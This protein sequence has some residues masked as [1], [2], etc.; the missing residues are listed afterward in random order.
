MKKRFS[1]SLKKAIIIVAI[2]VALLLILWLASNLGG[3]L[4]WIMKNWIP[5][6]VGVVITLIGNV[7]VD[8]IDRDE[9]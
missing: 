2:V 4:H 1:R 6:L 3:L 8:L 5:M 9:K 7:I